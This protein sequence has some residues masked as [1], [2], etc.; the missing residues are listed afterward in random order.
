MKQKVFSQSVLLNGKLYTLKTYKLFNLD[1]LLSFFC[2]NP[3]LIVIEYN[4][5]ISSFKN[6]SLIKLKFKDKIE[7]ITIV[8][9]G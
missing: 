6:W 9:G 7:T 5:K 1:D 2:F 8:G 4:G 3:N